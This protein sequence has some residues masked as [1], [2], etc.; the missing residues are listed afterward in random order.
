MTRIK[1]LG[2]SYVE[3][4]PLEF[5]G[6]C[7]ALWDTPDAEALWLLSRE[8]WHAPDRPRL[9]PWA[10]GV[11]GFLDSHSTDPAWSV[12]GHVRV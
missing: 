4:G 12:M 11:Y 7:A 10:G 3:F 8:S 2:S 1:S 9:V 5:G 6:A